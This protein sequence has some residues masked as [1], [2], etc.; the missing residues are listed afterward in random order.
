M[1]FVNQPGLEAQTEALA[2][3]EC[4]EELETTEAPMAAP[5]VTSECEEYEEIIEEEPEVF[6]AAMPEEF[7]IME[8]ECEE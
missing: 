2:T 7:E 5:E 1:R 4:E 3:E 6:A 8:E